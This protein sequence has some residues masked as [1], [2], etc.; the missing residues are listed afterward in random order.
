MNKTDIYPR[1]MN[2]LDCTDDLL[3]RFAPLSSQV[4]SFMLDR[5]LQSKEGAGLVA[6]RPA[7]VLKNCDTVNYDEP[8]VVE[9]Y[10]ILHFLDRFHRFQLIFLNLLEQGLLPIKILPIDVLDVGTGPAHALFALSDIYSGINLYAE[11]AG[12][13]MPSRDF[14]VDYL[15]GSE[16]KNYSHYDLVIFSNFLTSREQVEE[17]SGRLRATAEAN[18]SVSLFARGIANRICRSAASK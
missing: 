15:L 12:E 11:D 8:G 4:E 14:I 10:V 3:Q 6:S 18:Y 2:W 1:Y 5:V 16:W 7:D 17:L 9:A 13:F